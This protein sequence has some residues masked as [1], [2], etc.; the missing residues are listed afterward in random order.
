MDCL[1][2]S[3]CVTLLVDH[4]GRGLPRIRRQLDLD[5]RRLEQS[6]RPAAPLARDLRYGNRGAGNAARTE[7]GFSV[8]L[9]CQYLRHKTLRLQPSKRLTIHLRPRIPKAAIPPDH[10]RDRD[11]HRDTCGR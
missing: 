8:F 4:D 10:R 2:S 9:W 7:I 11:H 6:A 1:K 5:H 3:K